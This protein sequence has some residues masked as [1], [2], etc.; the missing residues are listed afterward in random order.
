MKPTKENSKPITTEELGMWEISN[1]LKGNIRGIKIW[2]TTCK[3][4]N[5]CSKTIDMFEFDGIKSEIIFILNLS[6]DKSFFVKLFDVVSA[7]AIHG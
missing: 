2:R 4:M 3:N 1:L 7:K 5:K 6:N